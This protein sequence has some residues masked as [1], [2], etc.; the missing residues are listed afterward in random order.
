VWR[1]RQRNAGFAAGDQTGP[2]ASGLGSKTS[3]ALP[4]R[5]YQAPRCVLVIQLPG[6]HPQY[7]TY[8]RRSSAALAA[9]QGT[10]S[11]GGTDKVDLLQHRAPESGLVLERNSAMAVPVST[12]PPM[13]TES[14]RCA[15]PFRLRNA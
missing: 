12:G 14:E 1:A 6:P 9:G 7:P 10:S 13:Y 8:T 5:M 2:H 11:A 15:A 4:S 3:A